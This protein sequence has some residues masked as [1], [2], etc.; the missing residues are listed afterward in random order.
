M[1]S[2][3]V[4]LETQFYDLDPM[5]VVWH[6]NYV[7]YLEQARC[8]LLDSIGYNYIEMEASGYAWPVVD[9]QIKYVGSLR[10]PQTFVVTA[11]ILEYENRLKIG[12]VVRDTDGATLTKA[13]TIQV[14]VDIASGE[15]HLESP[16]ILIEKIKAFL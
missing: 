1:I 16:A 14:A 3:D 12:Y 5:A 10:F 7:R 6:G 11:S 9:M 13:T 2:V 8:R 15:L 4:K